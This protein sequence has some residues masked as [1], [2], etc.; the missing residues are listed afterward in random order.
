M[1]EFG[2]ETGGVHG[3]LRILYPFRASEVALQHEI[4]LKEP[5]STL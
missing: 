3:F 5:Q 1:A 4:T 2:E